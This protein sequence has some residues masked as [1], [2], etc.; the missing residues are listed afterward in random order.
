MLDHDIYRVPAI[1]TLPAE[2]DLTNQQSVYDKLCAALASGS[3][4]VTADFTA[5]TFCDCSS[6]RGF[7]AVQRAAA[8]C[9]AEL[10][11]AIRPGTA[12]SRVAQLIRLDRGLPVYPSLEEASRWP[13][14]G[15]QSQI[16]AY[17]VG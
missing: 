17:P 8:S 2:I 5:T 16:V 6:L 3:P 15:Q 10:R 12:V 4:V 14:R 1:V 9:G 13:A 11:L 7:L